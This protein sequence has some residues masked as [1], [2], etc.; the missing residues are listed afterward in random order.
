MQNISLPP[1]EDVAKETLKRSQAVAKESADKYAIVT[2]DLA[3]AKIARQIQ[4]QN[5]PKCDDWF[6]QFGQFHTILSLFSSIGTI[7]E[8]N[9]AAYL[10]SEGKIIA[11]GSINK[12]LRVK[13]Y[14]CC[15]RGNLLLATAM[16][17]LHL[18]IF[19]EDMNILSTNLLQE[20]ENGAI[21]EDISEVPSNLYYIVTKYDLYLEETLNGKMGKTAQFWMTYTK[22][23][24]LFQL[25]KC[26][27]RINDTALYS[28]VLVEVTYIFFMTNHHIYACWM[29]FYS[30]D[31]A[32]LETSQPNLQT[33]FTEGGFSIN[34]TGKSFASVPVD[35]ALE[36]RINANAKTWL[37]GVMTFADISR[38]VN[39]WIVTASMKI[40][41][42]NAVLDYADMNISYDESKKMR[43]S[44]IREEQNDLSK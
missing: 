1:T 5:S 22:I 40:K 17:G 39:R 31:L 2:Y 11:G 30:V 3:V 21:A 27:I 8:R 25:M 18:E 28:F 41:I 33:F 38:A 6:I 12:F 13:P 36:Q 34:R 35:I 23:V 4:I 16:H 42:L 15:R 7:L 43:A 14:N 24:G 19:T 9:G 26:A 44:R 20:L 29:T 32:N 10:L 37:K